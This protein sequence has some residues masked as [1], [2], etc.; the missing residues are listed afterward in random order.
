MSGMGPSRVAVAAL[1]TT[2]V[3]GISG[4]VQPAGGSLCMVHRHGRGAPQQAPAAEEQ[5]VH[6]PRVGTA[7][8][9]QQTLCCALD[10]PQ[11]GPAEQVQQAL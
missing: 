6:R 5:L 2:A 1:Q 8:Q 10:V 11:V 7:E 4:A 9:V 3:S